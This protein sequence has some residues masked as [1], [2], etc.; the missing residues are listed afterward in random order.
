MVMR[1]SSERLKRT[2]DLLAANEISSSWNV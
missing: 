1:L 2:Q